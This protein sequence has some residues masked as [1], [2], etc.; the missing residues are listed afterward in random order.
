MATINNKLIHFKS[1]SDFDGRYAATTDGG[2]TYGDFLGTSIVFIQD[3]KQIWTH[4]QF[5]DANE[6]TLASLGITATAAE[7]NYMD[8]VTSNVQ[9]QLN[10]IK[11]SVDSISDPYEINLTNLLSAEDSESISTAI[12]G[13]DN[14]NATVQDNRIIVGTIS[15]GNVSVSIR[16][17]G[18]VTT[19]YYLLDSLVGL[20]LNEVAITNTSGTLSKSVTTH[21]VLTENM[22]IN[23]LNSDETTLPLSAAQGKV[24]ATDK[25]SKTD[26][27]LDTTDKTIVGAINELASKPSGVGKVDA[28]SYNSTGEIFN[29]YE[30][31]EDYY[32]N[33]AS[34]R[35]SHAEGSGTTASGEYSHAEGNSTTASGS[36]S[37]AE[38]STTTATGAYS[39]AEGDHTQ[40]FEVSEHAEG[41]YNKS[42]DSIS[43][44]VRVIHSVGIGSGDNNRKN[45]HEIKFNGDHYIYGLG[46]FDGTN[47][48]DA[49][50]LQEV[51]NSKQATIT[52]GT[53][54]EFEG[55]TLNVTLDT[56]VF[57][58]VETLPV[59]PDPGNENKIYLVPTDN[60]ST[61]A[62]FP[63][64]GPIQNEYTEYIWTG[65]T[66]E[67]LGKY[68]S[69]VDLTPYLKTTDAATTYLSKTDAADTYATKTELAGKQNNTDDT[70]NTTNKTV[71]GAI[72]EI[73][74]RTLN[75][76]TQYPS[77]GATLT[78]GTSKEPS[79]RIDFNSP[80]PA[81]ELKGPRVTDTS[82]PSLKYRFALGDPM[83]T[84]TEYITLQ[85]QTDDSLQT[86]NKTIAGAINEILP[87]ATGVGKVDPDSDGT[88]EIFNTYSGMHANH[89]SGSASHSEG[90]GTTASGSA[91]HSEGQGTTASGNYAHAEGYYTQS[92][93]HYEHAEGC[94]NLSN[95][96]TED[97]HN[98]RHS[99]GIGNS[100]SN[101]KNAHEIM[102]NG[103]HYVYGLGGYDGTNATSEDSK[104]LQTVVTELQTSLTTIQSKQTVYTEVP[105]LTAAYTMPANA[106]M[107]EKIYMITIGATVYDVTGATGIKW[108]GGVAPSVSANSILVV[109][110]LNNLATWQTFI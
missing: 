71:V 34:G 48:A 37:H 66:W 101:R 33:V 42:Y 32:A 56:T 60:V 75:L 104:T 73:E 93:N 92:K 40:A 62:H 69:E 4:G 20:T 83:T 15:N 47:S 18:N 64:S 58:V 14:L 86:T 3:A 95:S 5:Y 28:T 72:N 44:S 2:R 6:A 53:G 81:F 67:E 55:N 8:G 84:W 70:L 68:Y 49:Q 17:L 31:F 9:T 59:P 22:V 110:V 100:D 98:T 90:Q 79:T 91:S 65:S 38:G 29:C 27:N 35:Y 24:L 23:S 21:S 103:D 80:K 109:S 50:T 89:A 52:A 94:Y 19:L 10:E 105:E 82:N 13:I 25:Q 99:V 43:A 26:N 85:N 45:A 102:A 54:L 77:D 106:T 63:E 11:E 96:S 16:I 1:K 51:I 7:L 107:V 36:S 97:A 39:H 108:A 78:V 61:L 41:E 74:N 12:G 30:D 57:Y 87:K 76:S 88:G 46:N